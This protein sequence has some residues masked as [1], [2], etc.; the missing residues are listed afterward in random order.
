MDNHFHAIL[1]A[2]DL[3]GTVTDLKRFTAR[4][5][6]EKIKKEK[7]DWLLNQ[8]EF[9]CAAHKTASAHQV[10]QEGVHPQEIDTDEMMEQKFDYITITPSCAGSSLGRS[11]GVALPRTSGWWAVILVLRA[12]LGGRPRGNGVAQ[13]IAFPSGVWERGTVW[14]FCC[15]PLLP[16]P[17]SFTD[18]TPSMEMTPDPKS[19][20]TTPD[21]LRGAAIMMVVIFHTFLNVYGLFPWS[22]SV[23]DFS[24]FPSAHLIFLYPLSFGWAGVALFFVLSGFCIHLSYLRPSPFTWQKFYWGRFWRIYPA[25]LVALVVFTFKSNIDLHTWLGVKQFTLHALLIHNLSDES[26]FS[27]NA[28]FWSLATEAQLYLL[29]PIL[30]LLRQRW[31]IAGCLAVTFIVGLIWRVFAIT[32][33]GIPAHVITPAFS[34]PFMTWFDWTLGA[35]VAERVSQQRSA[36]S[37][38]YVWISILISLFVGSTLY[39][40][41]T[42]FSFSLAAAVSAVVLDLMLHINWRKSVFLGAVLFIGTISYSLYLWHLPLLGTRFHITGLHGVV[43]WIAAFIAIFALSSLSWYIIEKKG[44]QLGKMLQKQLGKSFLDRG[45]FR[46]GGVQ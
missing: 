31:G 4:A 40:P 21:V 29:F 32:M 25:Y 9:Y 3:A 13:T 37:N 15:S 18:A 35:F 2:P 1:A 41:L 42:P 7:R 26:F 24:H 22:A 27:I 10:W 34:S 17:T 14:T 16:A 5:L 39:K 45:P 23:R 44:V 11:T 6:L 38:H 36:F 33:W 30:I 20:L 43:R 19:H 12:I 8:L 28:S 46:S